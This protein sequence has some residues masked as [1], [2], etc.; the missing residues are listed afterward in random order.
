MSQSD[1]IQYLKVS[2]KLQSI[3][4]LP[5]I[6]NSGD[7]TDYTGY[8]IENQIR[9]SKQVNSQLT[10]PNQCIINDISTIDVSGC[11]VFIMCQNTNTRANRILTPYSG[12]CNPQR[13]LTKKINL[14]LCYPNNLYFSL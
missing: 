2:T 11:P 6:L 14:C 7:Y 4:K 3:K 5:P 13:P 8:A 10:L 9:S 12:Y 1:Y